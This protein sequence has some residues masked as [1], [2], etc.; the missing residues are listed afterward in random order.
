MSGGFDQILDFNYAEEMAQLDSKIAASSDPAQSFSALFGD[1]DDAL[2]AYLCINSFDGFPHIKAAMPAWAPAEIRHQAT[3]HFSE[4]EHVQ[5]ALSFW[6]RVRDRFIRHSGKRIA[7]SRVVDFGA[8]WGRIL[9]FAAKDIPQSCLWAVEPNPVFMDLLHQSKIPAQLVAGDWESR[10]RLELWEID[11]I[12]SYSILTHASDQL[13][14]NIVARWAEIT[15]P[16]AL[17]AFTVRPGSFL[18]DDKNEMAI[19]NAQE[20][21]ENLD[22]YRAGRLVYKPYPGDTH[23]G[24]AIAPEAYLRA[25]IT[26]NFRM[27]GKAFQFQTWNQIIYFI[28]RV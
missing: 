6:T 25:V 9:R 8:G 12:F 23:W 22:H 17:V 1:I 2:F 5:D 16:G 21:A 14:R 18:L 3:G 27:V 7:D 13:V 19:F 4:H 20:R 15:R 10:N 24:V 26:P 11:L 28:E